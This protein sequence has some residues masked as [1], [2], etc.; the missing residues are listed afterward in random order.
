MA[1]QDRELP[2]GT[3]T[4]VPGAMETGTS[5]SAGST[6]RN[7]GRGQ[8]SNIMDKVKS[9]TDKLSEQAG[10]KARD[11]VGQGIERSSEALASVGKLVGETASGLDERLGEEYGDYARRAA[12][13]IQS[14]ADR[15]AKKEADEVIGDTREFIR[16]SPAVAL[17]GA[18]IIG[19]AI[20]RLVKSGLSS[21]S[22]DDDDDRTG[23][24]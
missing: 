19:F 5:G 8:S 11:F 21:A 18:A 22:D 2:E 15:L 20:A 4:I 24:S 6:A 14:A 16:K 9:G 13:T 12:Q 17:A 3:D 10:D 1:Q 23:R 7:G